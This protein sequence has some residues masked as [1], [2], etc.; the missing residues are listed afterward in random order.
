MKV[1]DVS[2]YD[3]SPRTQIY[4]EETLNIVRGILDDIRECPEKGAREYAQRFGDIAEGQDMFVHK[5]KLSEAYES[6]SED[7][8]ALLERVAKRIE[9]FA[10]AQRDSIQDLRMPVEGGFVGHNVMP[11]EVAGCYAP[12]G[13]FP[14]PSSVFMTVIPARV[15]GVKHIYL[16]SPKPTVHTL[17]AAYIAGVDVMLNI[18]GAQAIGA[19]A[20]GMRDMKLADIIV[21]PGN[22]YVTAAKQIVSSS[23]AIDML[24]GPSELAVLADDTAD[25]VTIAADLL[26]QAEHDID[27][28]P[29]LVSLSREF[30][31]D[32]KK[33]IAKQLQELPTASTA[34][35]SMEKGLAVYASDMDDALRVMDHLAAEH[36]EVVC[37]DAKTVAKRIRHAG[38]LFIGNDAA[39][40]IGDYGAGPNHTLPTGGTARYKAGLSVFNFL[41]MTTWID[42]DSN[43]DAYPLYKD[44]CDLARI[45]G[46]EGH[47][48]AALKRIK[49][50]KS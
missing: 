3:F 4:D 44:A 50:E 20:Y 2:D 41:R 37:R 42:I 14:L 22:R 47:A 13:R 25:A 45:E 23:C 31:D 27:A 9:K 46:L 10:Q 38:G 34:S 8:R 39:E 1:I 32:V 7:E 33:E 6:I 40:V 35:V 48:R 11:M 21:G 16:A 19:M 24:A 49:S 28:W 17:A 36:V 12:G 29:V 30:I 26:A 43:V 18:G 5:D 15:A